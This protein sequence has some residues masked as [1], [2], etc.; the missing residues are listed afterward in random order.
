MLRT[1]RW[2]ALVAV[3]AAFLISGFPGRALAVDPGDVAFGDSIEAGFG[4]TSIDQAWVSLF[5]SYLTTQSEFGTATE[6]INL[7]IPGATARDIRHQELAAGLAAIATHAPVVV[8]WGGGGDDLLAFIGSPQAATCLRG[9]VSCLT[10][11]NAL[12]N[13][14]QQ[15]IDVTVRALRAAAG[16]EAKILLRT[17]YNPFLRAAC[18]GPTDDQTV[19]A[20]LVL[21]GEAPPFLTRGLNDRIRDVAAKYGARVVELYQLFALNADA[22]VADDCIHPNDAGH[23]AISAAAVAA[24]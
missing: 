15:T 16:P 11:L 5:W 23:A 21:E 19:L 9:N 20:A 24:F 3:F 8:T 14:V 7:G 10:R 12:L 6:L 2:S 13:E 17:Q 22:W 1:I 18:G 4:A